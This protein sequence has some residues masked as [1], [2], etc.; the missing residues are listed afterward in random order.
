MAIPTA[1][2]SARDASESTTAISSPL[3]TD[4]HHSRALITIVTTG[5]PTASAFHRRFDTRW[6]WASA[7]TDRV[8]RRHHRR[9]RRSPAISTPAPDTPV[10]VPAVIRWMWFSTCCS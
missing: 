9:D 4:R 6:W 5:G 10:N 2:A 3:R 7:A 1:S 8:K